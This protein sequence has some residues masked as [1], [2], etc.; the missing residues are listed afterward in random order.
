MTD[1]PDA[2]T[3]QVRRALCPTW[4]VALHRVENGEEDWVHR[5]EPLVVAEGVT[6]T[7]CMSIR[8]DTGA[9]DG[10]Y[11]IIGSREYSI[12]EAQD[13]VASLRAL[14]DSGSGPAREA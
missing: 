7:V 8:P 3:L 5:G 14:I 9:E 4:C 1:T 10:P 2:A 12:P 11:V 6:A 13:L